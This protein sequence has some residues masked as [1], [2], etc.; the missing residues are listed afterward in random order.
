MPRIYP[1]SSP[2]WQSR[3]GGHAATQRLGLLRFAERSVE[4]DCVMCQNRRRSGGIDCSVRLRQFIYFYAHH[5]WHPLSVDKQSDRIVVEKSQGNCRSFAMAI[6]SKLSNRVRQESG[7]LKAERR[8]HE[9]AGRCT[10]IDRRNPQ[11]SVHLALHISYPSD[12]GNLA[13]G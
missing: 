8:R 1:A 7:W 11:S 12:E 4:S 13:R 2:H 5:N 3:T 9:N 6:G 10:K